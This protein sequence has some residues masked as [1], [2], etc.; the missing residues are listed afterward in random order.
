MSRYFPSLLP[1]NCATAAQFSEQDLPPSIEAAILRRY[2]LRKQYNALMT[3]RGIKKP[4]QHFRNLRREQI[5][6]E[7]AFLEQW[8]LEKGCWNFRPEP[9]ILFAEMDTPIIFRWAVIYVLKKLREELPEGYH[10]DIQILFGKLG[11]DFCGK[12]DL[13]LDHAF[14]QVLA[15]YAELCGPGCSMKPNSYDR[16][17]CE[18]LQFFTNQLVAA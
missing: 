13:L 16:Y 14:E 11:S 10:R 5:P 3:D 2:F 9:Q 1:Y 6:E 8:L 17:I 12:K 4:N 18:R 15:L 7:I